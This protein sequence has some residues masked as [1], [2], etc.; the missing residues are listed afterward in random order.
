MERREIEAFLTLA[1]ELHFGRTAER[2]RLTSAR[3]SQTIQ[4]LEG[5]I[6]APLFDRS[7]RQ[8]SLTLIGQ[9]LRDDL[10]PHYRGI[11]EAE[12]TAISAGREVKGMLSVGFRGPMV[13]SL[14]VEVIDVFRDLYPGC[15]VR[16]R[17]I[18]DGDRYGPLRRGEVDV[19]IAELPVDQPDLVSG[20]VVVVDPVVLAVPSGHR[21][22]G[23]G[24]V[25]VDDLAGDAVGWIPGLPDYVL[26]RFVLALS[27]SGCPVHRGP[28]AGSWRELLALV[29]AGK[30][31]AVAG[32][33]AVRCYD[34]PGVTYVPFQ[35][36]PFLSY[37]LM[38][39]SGRETS[40]VRAFSGVV[41][42]YLEGRASSAARTWHDQSSI[43]NQP[44]RTS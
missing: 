28:A 15:E 42:D 25:G 33:Q 44:I 3:I 31:V 38:W 24:S 37:G 16:I 9:R 12:A 41:A 43:Q 17:E 8:V 10:I 30:C 13:G 19:L 11:Q 40:R 35:D 39:K 36:A 1:E 18:V 22:A 27:A 23:R 2:L 20:P 29:G 21:L 4:K 6:G 34:R 5:R 7:S 26:D 32:A 14:L